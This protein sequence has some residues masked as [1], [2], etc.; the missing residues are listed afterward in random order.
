MF[1]CDGIKSKVRQLLLG[2]DHPA[3][4]PQYTHRVAYRALVP[5]DKALDVLGEYKTKRLH[6]HIGPNAHII[7]YPVNSQLMGATISVYDPNEW[8]RDK[9]WT[10]KTKRKEWDH[11]FDGWSKPTRDLVSLFADELEHWA[12]FDLH[13]Y[14]VPKYNFGRICLVGDSAHASSHHHGAGASMGIEDALVINTLLPEVAAAVK[15]Q[16]MPRNDA[17]R[18]AFETYNKVRRPRSQWMVNSSR[19]VCEFFQQPDWADSLKRYKAETCFEEIKDRSFKIWHFNPSKMVDETVQDFEK[20][21]EDVRR[22]P[23]RKVLTNDV[24]K[25]DPQT[26]TTGIDNHTASVNIKNQVQTKSD[27]PMIGFGGPNHSTQ[28][29]GHVNGHAHTNGNSEANGRDSVH[30]QGHVVQ[31]SKTFERIP[32][33][34]IDDRGHQVFGMSFRGDEM[35]SSDIT[36]LINRFNLIF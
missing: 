1:A 17:L 21:L 26:S 16:V 6:F 30:S 10:G 27:A 20:K 33:D 7:H 15:L 34:A 35:K 32:L 2:T 11:V 8:P 25:T 24:V 12:L 13:E 18:M 14:P 36:D 29:N 31:D 22:A 3:S 28:P 4:Y 9:P 5:L 23:G 19:R